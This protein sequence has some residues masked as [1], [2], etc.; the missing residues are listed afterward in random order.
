MNT[1]NEICID[2]K[3]IG[4]N[5]PTYF[6]ADIAAN[7]NGE[8]SHA[9][10]LIYMAAEA[11]A[12][13]AKFQHFK[14]ETIVSDFGFESLGSKSSHQASWNKSV[15]QVYKEASVNLG[16]TPFLKEA[17]D[18]AGITFFTS[19]YDLDIVDAI[20][21]YVPAYKIGSGDI[22]WIEIIKYIAKKK[23]S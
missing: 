9:I 4:L 8:L 16:W 15:F 1:N 23:E 11:G 19:P 18:K 13:A 3:K 17:C 12:D 20:D 10:E 5:H 2:D 7:H 6:I 21:E 14:A 22:T